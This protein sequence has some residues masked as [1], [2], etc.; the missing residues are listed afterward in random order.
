MRDLVELVL[1]N[2][3]LHHLIAADFGIGPV[4]GF[5]PAPR[6][7]E[8]IVADGLRLEA[9]GIGFTLVL[10]PLRQRNRDGDLMHAVLGQGHADGV[11]DTVIQ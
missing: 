3:H 11:A 6:V 4:Q 10:G 7:A 2:G 9:W 1:P 5:G 8:G